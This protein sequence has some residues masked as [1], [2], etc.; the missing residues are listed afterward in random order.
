MP[1]CF[2][3]LFLSSMG[4]K[5]TKVDFSY[6]Q[7]EQNSILHTKLNYCKNLVGW[8]WLTLD[9]KFLVLH[10]GYSEVI[11]ITKNQNEHDDPRSRETSQ[12][13]IKNENF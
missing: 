10:E 12:K 8:F 11:I 4:K 9:K 5:S 1:I 13:L 6:I 2:R 7:C 3:S